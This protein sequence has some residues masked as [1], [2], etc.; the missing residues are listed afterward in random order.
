MTG[1]ETSTESGNWWWD[2]AAMKAPDRNEMYYLNFTLLSFGWFMF[3]HLVTHFVAMHK[4][5]IYREM[6]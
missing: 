3:V 4:T 2:Y 1:Q 5:S 6:N